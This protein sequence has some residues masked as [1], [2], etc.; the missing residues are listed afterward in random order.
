MIETG[1]EKDNLM[2]KELKGNFSVIT[3]ACNKVASKLTPQGV[4][5]GAHFGDGLVDLIIVNKTSRFNYFRY[6]YRSAFL[7]SNPFELPFVERIKV[8]EFR[9]RPIHEKS[10]I[11]DHKNKTCTSVWNCDGEVL[12]HAEI[13]VKVHCQILPVFARGPEI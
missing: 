8:R 12:S 4:A 10:G 1:E 6:L 2:A 13:Y 3:G 11:T 9:F 5:P 7:N